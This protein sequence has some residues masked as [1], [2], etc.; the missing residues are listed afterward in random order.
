MN[1]KSIGNNLEK[2]RAYEDISISELSRK[3]GISRPT[4]SKIEKGKGNVTIEKLVKIAEYFRI[5]VKSLFNDSIEPEIIIEKDSTWQSEKGEMRISIPQKN[6]TKFKE[7]LLYIL[8]QVGSKPNIGKT[9]I[10]KLLYFIDFDF[11][12]I[13]EEQL[14]GATYKKNKYGPTPLEFRK[15]INEMEK[16]KEIVTVKNQYF[17]H[18]QMKYLP[19]RIPKLRELNAI[20]VKV[21]DKV[22]TRLSDYDATKISEYSH[23]D[24]PWLTTEDGEII[25]YESVFYRTEEYSARPYSDVA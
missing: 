8:N 5:D 16:N 12:E 24:I 17:N 4:I 1:N 22:L 9:V 10:Y 25:D 14:I 21:I 13:F 20:E 15:I 23:E 6:Y 7:V 11:Y 2:L 3:T 18:D 19:L